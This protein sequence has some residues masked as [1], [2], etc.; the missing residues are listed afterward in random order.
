MAAETRVRTPLFDR[1]AGGERTLTVGGLRESVRRELELLFNTR[2]SFPSHRL[3]GA[4]LTVIDYGIPPLTGFA[5]RNSDDQIKLANALQDAIA[6][7][8]PRLSGVR[9]RAVPPAVDQMYLEFSVEGNLVCD[10]V[11]EPV[12]FELSLRQGMVQVLHAGA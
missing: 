8:E 9:V 7:F 5:A 10:N 1:L 4:P 12:S 11:R 6:A 2:S 3:P